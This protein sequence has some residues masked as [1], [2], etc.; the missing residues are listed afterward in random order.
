[1]SVHKFILGTNLVSS[2]EISNFLQR[3]ENRGITRPAIRR[4]Q[5]IPQIDEELA[6]NDNFCTGKKVFKCPF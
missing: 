6:E 4:E 3:Q 5:V 2:A 1:V